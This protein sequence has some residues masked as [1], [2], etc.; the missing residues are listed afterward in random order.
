MV[1]GLL[2][3]FVDECVHARGCESVCLVALYEAAMDGVP[4]IWLASPLC[5]DSEAAMD[6]CRLFGLQAYFSIHVPM[7]RTSAHH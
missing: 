3:R 7:D 6:W 5:C 1:A 2:V 4:I